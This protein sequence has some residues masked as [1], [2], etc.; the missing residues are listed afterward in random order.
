MWSLWTLALAL[1]PR[2]ARVGGRPTLDLL[3]VAV[4]VAALLWAT[5]LCWWTRLVRRSAQWLTGACLLVLERSPLVT[6][7][8]VSEREPPDRVPAS[9]APLPWEALRQLG[10]TPR[11][12]DRLLLYRQVYRAGHYQPDPAALARLAFARWLAQHGKLSG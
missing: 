3:T 4:L 6:C 8:G 7:L 10:F 11:Q 1:R 2:P 5:L 12:I 9:P